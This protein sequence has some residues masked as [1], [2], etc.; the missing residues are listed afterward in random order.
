[1]VAVVTVSMAQVASPDSEPKLD[2]IERVDAMLRDFIHS[3][4]RKASPDLIVLPELWAPG[5]FHFDDYD[6]LAEPFYGPTLEMISDFAREFGIWV[7]LG[8]FIERDD[9]GQLHNTAVLVNNA[10]E[11]ALTYRKVHVFGYESREAELLTP[12][13][14]LPVAASPAGQT[15]GLTC[16][17]L[18]FPGLWTELADRGAE[19]VILPAAWPKKRSLHWTTLTQAR[20]IEHQIWIFACGS[21]GEQEGVELAGRSRIIDP[22]GEILAEASASEEEIITAEI[23]RQTLADWRAEFPVQDDRL[24]NYRALDR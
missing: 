1:V 24:E 16:Y 12:G 3:R 5:F 8:S 11:P 15:T 9:Q 13:T 10:G 20:A 23:H 19:A 2:R 4:E 17:D 22:L 14:S 7:H 6:K 21:V 18:R